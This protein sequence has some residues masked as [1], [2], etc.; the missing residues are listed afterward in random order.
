MIARSDHERP[1]GPWPRK[2][3]QGVIHKITAEEL[4][5]WIVHVDEQVIVINKSGELPCHPSKDG[6]WSSLAG[7]VREYFGEASAHLVFRLDRETSG[8]VIFARDPK[9]ARRL[10]MAA[11]ER[12][13]GKTYLALLTGE[14]AGD[15]TVD[16]PLGDDRESPVTVKAT[17]VPLGQG[18][19]AV[20]HFVPIARAGGFT[21]ARVTTDTGRKHQIR[22]H[23]QWLGHSLVGDKIYGPDARLFLQFIET[24]WTPALAEKLLLPRQGL[25]CAEIDLRLAGVEQVFCV[26][27]AEDMREFCRVRMGLAADDARL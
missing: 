23:A 17:V 9:T 27:M 5:R 21:L 7:A 24:G 6:P 18:Q 20:T 22:A 25:H 11:Q 26:P 16:Q 15:V 1:I 10:Q 4:S 3:V 14:L 13:Y 8:A 19:T 12:R 2:L